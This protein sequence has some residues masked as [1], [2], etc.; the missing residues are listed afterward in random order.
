MFKVI[1][2]AQ[3]LTMIDY[4]ALTIAIK[5]EAFNKSGAENNALM[6]ALISLCKKSR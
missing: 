4:R 2:I 5:S 1:Q 6:V 3:L